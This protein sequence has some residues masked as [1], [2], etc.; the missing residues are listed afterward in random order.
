MTVET[1]T[2]NKTTTLET[3]VKTLEAN[4]STSTTQGNRIGFVSL[5]CPK[6]LVDSERILTQLRTEGYDVVPTYNDA[7]LV[8]VNTCGFIDS[9]VQESLDT[10]GEALKENG[11][12]IV[13]GCLGVKEDEI[14][15]VHPNVLAITGPHAYESVVEQVHDHMPKPEHNPFHNLVPDHGVKLTPRHYAYLKISE[16][17]NHRCTF[18]IIPS[19]RG[20]LVSR[21]VGSVLDE[22]KRLKAAGVSELLVISQDTSA[23]GVDVKHRTGFWDGMP[24]K[25]HMQQLSAKLGELDMWVRLHYV[26]PYPH[27]DELIS[28]MNDGKVL[29]Y[30]D[31]PLQHA[32]KRI[33]RLMKRPGSAERTL[34]RIKK[35]REECPELVIRSTFI[36]GFP[37]E[38]EEEFE[39]LLAFLKEAQLDRVG[40]FAYSP[41]EGARA[42][43]L[44]DP[45][46]EDVKQERLAR[47]MAV[48]SEISAQ[49]L[50]DRIGNEYQIVIDSVDSEGAVGRSYAEAP[51]VDGV[52]HLN[53]VYDVQPGQRVWA[54]IIHA[55]E[56]DLWAVL[57][58][59]QDD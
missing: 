37:G 25:T 28:L 31:I 26:Y 20:D 23:Y 57:S 44:P 54:E 35:W 11:K 18:C 29:P 16:G 38:T 14:R 10:I 58:E 30:L 21:P 56:H 55:D 49:R 51:E 4:R 39:E 46:P 45:V 13:T 43:D 5:G 59:D 32:N 24:V 52:I 50:Q 27:V 34:E 15:E 48:Q 6:N 40:C 2:P 22:A 53:G 36:V 12:V 1:Y 17:C 7:D 8:I 41:V 19:M 42:N 33:L 9:A 3:P 47:F